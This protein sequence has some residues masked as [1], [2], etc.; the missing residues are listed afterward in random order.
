MTSGLVCESFRDEVDKID[1]FGLVPPPPPVFELMFMPDAIEAL[2]CISRCCS[3]CGC[4][5]LSNDSL[6]NS[7][8]TL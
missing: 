6:L 2:E 7:S 8:R 4:L 3:D 1:V 5:L